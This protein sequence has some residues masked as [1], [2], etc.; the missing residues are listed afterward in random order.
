MTFQFLNISTNPLSSD[1]IVAGLNLATGRPSLRLTLAG[2][3]VVRYENAVPA[4]MIL[5]IR[6]C[7]HTE[8][9]SYAM[10]MM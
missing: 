3:R 10:K 7:S 8:G 4:S 1:L 5:R 6:A 9:A 2:S